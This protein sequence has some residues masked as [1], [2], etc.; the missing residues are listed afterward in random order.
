MTHG[1]T[2]LAI[3]NFEVADGEVSRL[4]KAKNL[5]REHGKKHG[6]KRTHESNSEGMSGGDGGAE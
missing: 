2:V 1:G 6:R 5:L 4:I 3:S